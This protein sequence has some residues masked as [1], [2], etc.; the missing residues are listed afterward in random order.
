MYWPVPEDSVI[1][2]VPG[3]KTGFEVQAAL[4]K[5]AVS[6]RHRRKET[7]GKSKTHSKKR[8]KKMGCVSSATSASAGVGGGGKYKREKILI[9]HLIVEDPTP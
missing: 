2:E 5:K 8:K 9:G 7:V 3:P 1:E 6:E 4:W